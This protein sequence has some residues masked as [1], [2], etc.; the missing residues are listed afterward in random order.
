MCLYCCV[1][2]QVAL[3]N[4]ALW[5]RPG[6]NTCYHSSTF[7]LYASSPAH[8]ELT[9]QMDLATG[10]LTQLHDKQHAQGA[11]MQQSQQHHQDQQ[12]Q[13]QQPLGSYCIIPTDCGCVSQR[14]W[15]P[16]P[17]GTEVPITLLH[18]HDHV[19]DVTRPLLVEVY[20]A[21]GHV[22]ESEFKPHRLPLL[23]RGWSV[24]LAHVRGGGELG[25]RWDTDTT[26][27]SGT[28]LPGR[29]VILTQWT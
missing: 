21:Y 5:L 29:L 16:A 1:L 2:L 12:Q 18:P 7:R 20:G 14:L 19:A 9:L 4:W 8:P 13:Q 22:L 3:P 28:A 15:A 26:E 6:N 10:A 25:R 11:L 24:A 17:D 27:G 23:R